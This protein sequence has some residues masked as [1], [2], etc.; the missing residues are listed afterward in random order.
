[1]FWSGETAQKSE[2]KLRRF[3][4]MKRNELCDKIAEY[5]QTKAALGIDQIEARIEQTEREIDALNDLLFSAPPRSLE[6]FHALAEWLLEGE[7]P[8]CTDE[9]KLLTMLANIKS[10]PA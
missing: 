6:D 10:L 1:M 7:P 2:A 8:E 5:E 3:A 4:Q 9:Y